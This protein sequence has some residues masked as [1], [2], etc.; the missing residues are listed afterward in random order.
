L[1]GLREVTVAPL[2]RVALL[3]AP[4]AGVATRLEELVLWLPLVRTLPVTG[5]VLVVVPEER[6]TL[7]EGVLLLARGVTEEDP[8]AGLVRLTL[9]PELRETLLPVLRDALLPELRVVPR[10][11]RVT[12]LPELRVGP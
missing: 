11:L 10:P 4:E 6:L 9:L 12:E 7:E 1:L 8:V 3:L 5:A 2:L